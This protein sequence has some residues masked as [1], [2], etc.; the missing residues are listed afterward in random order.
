MRESSHIRFAPLKLQF[1]TQYGARFQLRAAEDEMSAGYHID[2]PNAYT[3]F[4][5][6]YGARSVAGTPLAMTHI[7]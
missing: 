3:R 7:S 6:Q 4:K 5:W 1:E 2:W